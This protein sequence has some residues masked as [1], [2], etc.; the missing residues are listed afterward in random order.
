LSF[1]TALE[2]AQGMEL[3]AKNVKELTMPAQDP[4]STA[5]PTT[6]AQNPINQIGDNTANKPQSICYRCGKVGYYAS[7]C[8][9]KETICN[10]C[11]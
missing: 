11:G 3:A 10:K 5:R 8:K 9:Y 1:K 6:V 4:L 7:F 2:L